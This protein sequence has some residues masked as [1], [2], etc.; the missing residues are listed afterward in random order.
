M[1]IKLSE[2]GQIKVQQM[3]FMLLAITLFFILVGIFLLVV[4][5]SGLKE[6]AIELQEK[7]ALLLVTRLANSP[8]F[9]CGESFGSSKVNC[10]D[11]DKVMMLKQTS[12]KY[13][14]FWGASNII[15]RKV[16]P[17]GNGVECTLGNYPDCDVIRVYS[18]ENEG[19]EVSNFVIL[20]RKAA[21][22]TGSYDKCEIAKMSVSYELE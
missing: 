3:L 7:N 6:S 10:V 21:G 14:N 17:A 12:E 15:I 11:A 1:V 4:G 20:C 19:A 8:E 5:S 16:Y 2:K 13:K 18:R 9:S 22:E